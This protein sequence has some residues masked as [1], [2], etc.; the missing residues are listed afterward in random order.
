MTKGEWLSIG[1]TNNLIDVETREEITF[2][3]AYETWF[4][5]KINSVK[6]QSC[7]RIE[8][9]YNKYYLGTAFVEKCISS[10]SEKDVID[11]MTGCVMQ[12]G[13][14]SCKEFGR[15]YQIINNVL[16]Y[17]KDLGLGGARLYD[18]DKIKRYVPSVTV[19]K[20]SKLEYAVPLRDI[21][22]VI[23]MVVNKDVYPVKRCACLCLCMNFFLGLRIGELA[24]LMFSDFDFDKNV[25]RVCKTECKFYERQ[26]D[27]SRKGTMVYRVM[28]GTKTISG[29]REIPLMPEVKLIYEKIKVCHVNHNYDS[30]YLAFDGSDTILV[31]S[32]DRTLRRLCGL[33]GVKYFNSHAIRKTFVTMLHYSGVPTRVIADIVGHS[34]V[35]T[36]E[37]NYI[38]SYADN[39]GEILAYM[40]SGIKLN[41]EIVDGGN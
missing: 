33:C 23:D 10:I 11:F 38:L 37:K 36:T 39:R 40:K 16:V 7:D 29:I 6:L 9:T 31:R 26:D 34:E 15:F 24:S 41:I 32:L 18:W 14:M 4:R 27:G 30:P 28:D 13:G 2:S 25:V 21:E 19:K 20:E 17:M 35:N 8:I 12:C 5:M 22:R 3:Q 1:Y